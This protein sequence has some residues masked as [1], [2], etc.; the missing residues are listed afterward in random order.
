M[1]V[2][3]NVWVM[4]YSGSPTSKAVPS[5]TIQLSKSNYEIDGTHH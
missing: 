3:P 5:K 1:N 2:R 4:I